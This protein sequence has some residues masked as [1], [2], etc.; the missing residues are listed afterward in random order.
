MSNSP[1]TACLAM[2]VMIFASVRRI[3]IDWLFF[4][5]LYFPPILFI[6]GTLELATYVL[7]AILCYLCGSIFLVY[8]TF[9][10]M[11]SWH[12]CIY[13][14]CLIIWHFGQYFVDARIKNYVNSACVNISVPSPCLRK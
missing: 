9:A 6:K 12:S 3:F 13:V 4:L 1:M 11:S 7:I 8:S 10:G 5:N 2:F 14:V